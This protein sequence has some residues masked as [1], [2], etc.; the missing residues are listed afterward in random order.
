MN[1]Q[2]AFQYCEIQRTIESCKAEGFDKAFT[3]GYF[4]SFG[5]EVAVAAKEQIELAFA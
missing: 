4:K 2:E 5:P 1:I 3:M